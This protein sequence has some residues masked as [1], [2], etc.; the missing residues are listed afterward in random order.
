MK[1]LLL[2][3][4]LVV[5][6]FL[7]CGF[8]AE[9]SS[10]QRRPESQVTSANGQKAGKGP[11][12]AA[13]PGQ[14]TTDAKGKSA[15]APTVSRQSDKIEVTALPPEIAVK[16]VKDSIDRT[17]MWCTIILTFVGAAGTLA[18]V[19]TLHQVKRQADTLDDHKAKF[20]ELA[21]AAGSNAAAAKDLATA[22]EE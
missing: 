18:A 7:P 3:T 21:A 5:I 6:C 17:I 4:P 2:A 13:S 9:A 1:R 22:A 15:V 20:E 10:S 16:Q 12:G 8:Q 14:P 19:R 11:D